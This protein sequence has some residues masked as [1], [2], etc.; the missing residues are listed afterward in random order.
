L[1]ASTDIRLPPGPGSPRRVNGALFLA[2]RIRAFRRW[3]EQFG[4]IYFVDI[5]N[6]GPTVVIRGAELHR[7]VFTAKANILHAG[8]NALGR[9]LG[10][11][12]IFSMD[13]DQHLA[14]R[15][16]LL[17]PFHGERMRSYESLVEAEANREMDRWPVDEP[18]P[19]LKSFNSITLRVIL[20]AVFGAEGKELAEL[21][22]II[23]PITRYGQMRVASSLLM[24]D[25]GRFSPGGR[26]ERLMTRFHEIIRTLIDKHLADPGLADRIDILAL[27]LNS[28][29][30]EGRAVDYQATGEELM[31]ILVAGHETTASSLAWNIERIT[32]HPEVLDRLT[33]EARTDQ[34]EYRL[35]VINEVLRTRPVIGMTGRSVFAE[36]FELDGW[37]LPAGTRILCNIRETNV[38][39][40]AHPEADR[41][42]PDRYVGKKPDTYSWIPFGGGLRRCLGAAFAQ[43]EMDIVLRT[44]LRRFDLAA[45][46]RP[47]EGE[48]FKGLAYAPSR[49]GVAMVRYRDGKPPAR[50]EPQ[51]AAGAR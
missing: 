38:D 40:S 19:T 37:K 45:T 29:L 18:F 25:Y 1:S 28:D 15:R 2:A 47:P 11:G 51:V 9:T 14:E 50:L 35:A 20:R 12:S 36:S 33:A 10:P 43:M 44:L 23:P 16:K 30:Q 31:T 22:Q 32:R 34:N 26:G 41:F 6:F 17:P 42:N 8:D 49:G 13:E 3:H 46:S 48:R 4:D 5:A 39:P 7:K 21:E 24:R 27:M